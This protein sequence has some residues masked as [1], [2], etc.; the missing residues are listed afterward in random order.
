M[1]ACVCGKRPLGRRV[2]RKPLAASG[3]E[4]E[5]NPRARSARLRAFEK[6]AAPPPQGA[7]AGS[8]A[9]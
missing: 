1:P 9:P 3:A 5:R 4:A 8:G 7:A 2:T 6:A